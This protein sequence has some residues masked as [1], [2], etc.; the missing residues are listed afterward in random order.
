[1]WNSFGQNLWMK[2]NLVKLWFVIV[3]L[4]AF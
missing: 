1:L 3:T 4:Y 2:P